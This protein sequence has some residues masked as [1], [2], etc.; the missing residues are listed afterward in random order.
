MENQ[1]IEYKLRYEDVQ[2]MSGRYQLDR[3][4]VQSILGISESTQFRYLKRNSELNPSIADRWARFERIVRQAEELFEDK[5]ETQRWL[6]TPKEALGSQ[7]P[8]DALATDAG[9]KQVEELLYRAEYGI[10]G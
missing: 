9:A 7:T 1:A 6:S 2:E 3:Q 8:L 10:F 4:V 5:Q